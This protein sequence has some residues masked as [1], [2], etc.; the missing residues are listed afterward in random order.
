MA[1][2]EMVLAAADQL[3]ARD[4]RGAYLTALL[5][6]RRQVEGLV[7]PGFVAEAGSGRLRDLLRYLDAAGR[8]LARLPS[9][10]RRDAERQ[11]VIEQLERRYRARLDRTHLGRTGDD[12]N[13]AGQDGELAGIRWM[14]EELR[15][16]LWAQQL[17]TPSPISEARIARALERLGG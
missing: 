12:A 5:D 17:G 8:R 15:V 16:S 7:H 6:V 13:E 2:A 14:I 4:S 11:S 3:E 1:A 10:A 9:E